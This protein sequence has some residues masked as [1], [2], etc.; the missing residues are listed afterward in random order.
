LIDIAM[1]WGA[2]AQEAA[3]VALGQVDSAATRAA[4]EHL[5]DARTYKVQVAAMVSEAGFGVQEAVEAMADLIVNGKGLDPSVAAASVRR[6][7]PVMAQRLTTSLIA[8]CELS[9]DVG[10]RLIESWALIQADAAKLVDWGLAHAT[11]DIRMQTIWLV[12]QRA[13]RRYLDAIAPALED[14][15]A[16]V[17]S[18][19]AWSIVRLIG[20]AYEPGVE[21]LAG[22]GAAAG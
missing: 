12:G 20:D 7:P 21:I 9:A 15:D 1:H 6:L 3:A 16:G 5:R 2:E 13:E 19:A 11:A 22:D 4:L 18:M 14:A 10:T 8:C 17:R